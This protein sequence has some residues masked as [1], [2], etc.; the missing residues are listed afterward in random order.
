MRRCKSIVCRRP[1]GQYEQAG[2]QWRHRRAE[3]REVVAVVSMSRGVLVTTGVIANHAWQ[4]MPEG[5]IA[6]VS[7]PFRSAPH[8]KQTESLLRTQETRGRE[9]ADQRQTG[10]QRRTPRHRPVTPGQS[11]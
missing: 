4:P 1:E 10:S 3:D 11:A 2:A 5:W 9:E 7:E 6:P 8:R